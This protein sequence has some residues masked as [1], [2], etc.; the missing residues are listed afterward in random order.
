MDTA[1]T[2]GT[3]LKLG[4][5]FAG[6]LLSGVTL[7]AQQD[8]PPDAQPPCVVSQAAVEV[9]LSQRVLEQGATLEV[10]VYL[11]QPATGVTVDAPTL[12]VHALKLGTPTTVAPQAWML[13]GTLLVIPADAALGTHA[14]TL[15]VLEG[16]TP[17]HTTAVTLEVIPRS[18]TKAVP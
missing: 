15:E 5:F 14:L 9:G 6:A 3:Q 7:A 12:Q 18:S 16:S 11:A 10:V 13:W 1:A 2:W 8:V 4:F 17:T